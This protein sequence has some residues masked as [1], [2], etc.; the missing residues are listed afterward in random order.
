MSIIGSVEMLES[1][2]ADTST[3]RTPI[4]AVALGWSPHAELN[5][6]TSGMAARLTVRKVPAG[7][8]RIE[9]SMMG[10][11]LGFRSGAISVKPLPITRRAENRQEMPTHAR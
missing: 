6:A 10:D 3:G 1:G 2:W 8:R 11:G 7:K 4:G 5:T 9:P